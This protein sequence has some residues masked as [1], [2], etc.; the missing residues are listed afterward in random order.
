VSEIEP[1]T[2]ADTLWCGARVVKDETFVTSMLVDATYR[3]EAM[4]NTRAAS[5]TVVAFLLGGL[6]AGG[7]GVRVIREVRTV[8]DATSLPPSATSTT[9]ATSVFYQVDPNETLISS[10]ALVPASAKIRDSEFAVGY[11]LVSLAPRRTVDGAR[12]S[13]DDSRG[14]GV[15]IY[16]KRWVIETPVG[17]IE[18][19]PGNVRARVA[20][21]DVGEGFSVDDV[22]SIRVV[23]ALAPFPMEVAVT[24]SDSEPVAEVVQG[25]TIALVNVVEQGSSTIVQVEINIEDTEIVDFFVT[26]DGPGWRSAAFDAGGRQRVTLTWVGGPLPSTIPLLVIGSLWIP[27]AGPFDVSLEGV[28]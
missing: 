6:A 17:S 2:A 5:L 22:Q 9:A 21:F 7:I 24:L 16:P 14:D 4:L 18:G 11:D 8:D 10:V 25:V 15:A 1:R 27:I 26:G 13:L 12:S 20:R 23:E 28:R 3:S 19:G